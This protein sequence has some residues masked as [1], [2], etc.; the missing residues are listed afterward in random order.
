MEMFSGAQSE[1]L[2]EQTCPAEIH[3]YFVDHFVNGT[4]DQK[5]FF[6]YAPSVSTWGIHRRYYE[7]DGK[8]NTYGG[9]IWKT[10]AGK[11]TVGNNCVAQLQVGTNG[12]PN[13]ATTWT[14]DGQTYGLYFLS[15]TAQGY[16]PNYPAVTNI[17]YEP[18]MFRVFVEGDNL[19]KFVQSE[20][21]THLVDAGAITGKYCVGSFDINSNTWSAYDLSFAKGISNDKPSET[22]PGWEGNMMFGAPVNMSTNDLKVYV[23]FYYMVKGWNASGMTLRAGEGGARP[24]NGA[25]GEGG[26]GISTGVY[27]LDY[28]SEIVDQTFINSL[29][30][31]S[32]KPF[33]GIN[34]V[35]TRYSDGTTRTTKVIR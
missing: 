7:T 14:V 6:T 28:Q 35:I 24:G 1:P 25:E 23:R 9:P 11:V 26:A 32:D 10:G 18:Y 22:N 12:Q 21:G 3:H 13:P 2:F 15:A 29:G 27:D 4:Y 16:L 8:D 34:I 31:Q 33:S 19:R 5:N 20:D 17:E 30:M